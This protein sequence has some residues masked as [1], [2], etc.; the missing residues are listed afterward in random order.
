MLAVLG[1]EDFVGEQ[2][3]GQCFTGYPV[4]AVIN[5]EA[6][7]D[8]LDPDY[9]RFL[10]RVAREWECSWNTDAKSYEMKFPIKTRN[11]YL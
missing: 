2:V 4:I 10:D 8:S 5:L 3:Q 9:Y 11:A 6:P 1:V 7:A